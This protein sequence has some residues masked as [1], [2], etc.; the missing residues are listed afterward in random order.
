MTVVQKK[1]SL[2]GGN[3]AGPLSKG[4]PMP[5]LPRPNLSSKKTTDS[6]GAS[7]LSRVEQILKRSGVDNVDVHD[8]DAVQAS[9]RQ[10]AKLLVDCD[11][12]EREVIRSEVVS[13][14]SRAGLKDA[15]NL[16]TAVMRAVATRPTA[17]DSLQG[18]A[19]D[20]ADPE[21]WPDEVDGAALLEELSACITRYVV[22]PTGADVAVALW[23]VHTCLIDEVFISPIL[24]IASPVK[25][26]GKSTLLMLS[27]ALCHRS[28]LASNISPAALFRTIEK[29]KPTLLIDEAETFLTHNADLR[30]ILNAGHSKKTAKVHRTVG[31]HHEPRSFSTFCPKAIALIGQLPG[32]LE[33]RAIVIPMRRRAR[34]EE[35][36]EFRQDR[37]DAEVEPL[38]RRTMR[39][40]NDHRK[41]IAES[42]PQMPTTLNDR[43]RDNW[44][45]LI[46]IADAAGGEWPDIAREVAQLFATD[47]ESDR[48][49][50][51]A[52]LSD[53]RDTVQTSTRDKIS[54]SELVS[55]LIQRLDRPW[56]AYKRGKALTEAQLARILKPFG[57]RP[58]KI[59]TG[60]KAVQGYEVQ[61]FDDAFRRYLP[62]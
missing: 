48:A 2:R 7:K 36:A 24:G 27:Q 42:E 60:D 6:D 51:I 57:I 19:I 61:W 59:R 41:A 15:R 26:C 16:V 21:P 3:H 12:I 1:K 40:A 14:L 46:A 9:L 34:G 47:D 44:R 31:D 55:R 35:I 54:S 22:L 37:I 8:P 56:A 53:I 52:L 49:D 29:Y 18:E 20:L 62:D 33:D 28:A 23:I 13:R 45:P 5:R 43:A 10:L 58:K 30:G 17:T 11:E 32:T 4:V 38:R 39:W 25:R 50:G